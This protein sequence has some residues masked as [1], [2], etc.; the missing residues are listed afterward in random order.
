MQKQ[1]IFYS[2]QSDLPNNTNRGFIQ[3]QLEAAVTELKITEQLKVDPVVDRDTAGVAGSPDIGLTIFSKISKAAVFVCDVSIIHNPEEGRPTPNP[4][5]LIELGYALK[6]MDASRIIMV[7]NKSFGGPE[8]LP[9]D[10]KQKRVITYDLPSGADKKEAKKSLKGDFVIAVKAVLGELEETEAEVEPSDPTIN[11]IEAI[12]NS[13]PD[14]HRKLKGY[15]LW[16]VSELDKLD[17]KSFEGEV[18]EKLVQAIQET[19]S[20][21]KG[22][23]TIA[24]EISEYNAIDAANTLFKS[25]EYILDRYRKPR[26]FSGSW[27]TYEF[28]LYK[29]VGQELVTILIGYLMK[30][31]RWDLI[32]DLLKKRL[33]MENH[34]SGQP[35]STVYTGLSDYL[36][37]LDDKRSRR[38]IKNGQQRTSIHADLLKDRHESMPLS[39]N[40]T[41]EEFMDAD[42]F[43]CLYSFINSTDRT[44]PWWP[45]TWVYFGSRVP[46]FVVDSYTKEGAGVLAKALGLESAEELK[47]KLKAAIERFQKGV[48]ESRNGYMSD[49]YWGF[50]FEKI[51]S[52]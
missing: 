43:L 23:D 39:E 15:M 18:D 11:V 22:F 24:N 10:L 37:L 42:H 1:T 8:L 5:V 45:R 31:E 2:W 35:D 33:H 3:E 38:L 48:S 28:D 46:R 26:G 36:P 25:F 9:F 50:D 47:T 40:M 27:K 44:R 29:F 21:V 17:G 34:P 12:K 30:D 4:N 14:T 52:M 51:A 6:T 32:N 49:P 13:R 19:V 20:L 7:M 16:L 41:W